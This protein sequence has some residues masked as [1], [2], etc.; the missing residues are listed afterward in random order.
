M[1]LAEV[2][3]IAIVTPEDLL[4]PQP[5]APSAAARVRI[6]ENFHHLIPVLPRFLEIRSRSA[7]FDLWRLSGPSIF[8]SHILSSEPQHSQSKRTAHRESERAHRIEEIRPLRIV[9]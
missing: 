9:E 3:E 7:S 1:T 8:E 4:L 2:G 5:N 6:V